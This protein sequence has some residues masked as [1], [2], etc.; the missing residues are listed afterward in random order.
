MPQLLLPRFEKKTTKKYSSKS[1]N[2]KL[3]NKLITKK[4]IT[5]GII[6]ILVGIIFTAGL[7]AWYSKDLPSP[8]K[9]IDR[10]IAQSTKIYDRTGEKI[11]YD[12]HGNERRTLINI[13][14][15]PE[16]VIN[17]AIAIEDKNFYKHG[18]ISIWGIIRGQIVPR[19]QGKRAQGG[20]T[21]TQQ[22]VKNAILT[23]E[24]KISR[25]IKEWILSYQIEKKYSK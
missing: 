8:N 6:I 18:G 2:K 12:I 22:F 19:L 5:F 25:K 16:H 20:S 11:L 23:N 17:A 1:K 15:L 13:D 3:T 4:L 9:I 24:R 21:L 14:E 7:F 10:S